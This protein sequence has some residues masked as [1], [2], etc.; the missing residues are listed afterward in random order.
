MFAEI[1]KTRPDAV[2]LMAGAEATDELGELADGLG[3]SDSARFSADV[4]IYRSCSAQ[5]MLLYSRLCGRACP[6]P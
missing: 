2:L 4:L 5:W 1:K 3:I 6:Y